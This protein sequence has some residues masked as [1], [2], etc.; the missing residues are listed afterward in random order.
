[1]KNNHP[2]ARCP[3][4]LIVSGY[5]VPLPNLI[6][7]FQLPPEIGYKAMLRDDI[8]GKEQYA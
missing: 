5:R 7:Q 6:A 4:K 8:K 2:S 1:V 3:G